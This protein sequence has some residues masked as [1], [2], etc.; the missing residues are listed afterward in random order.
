MWPFGRK[1][2]SPADI[3]YEMLPDL[4]ATAA[5]KWLR[6]RR[7]LAF[8]DEVALADQIMMFS[9]PAIEGIRKSFPE[10]SN[11]PDSF[12]TLVCALG[13]VESGTHSKAEVE[14]ALGVELPEMNRRR[15]Q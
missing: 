15:A 8:N 5:E 2:K 9:I 10:L 13:V 7:L 14:T 12:F 4:V 11:S 6:F 1:K 3:A